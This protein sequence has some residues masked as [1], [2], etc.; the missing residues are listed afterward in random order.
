MLK[1]Q[2]LGVLVYVA[3]MRSLIVLG[4]GLVAPFMLAGCGGASIEDVCQRSCEC[5]DNCDTQQSQCEASGKA[6]EELSD[7]LGCRDSWDAYL[8]CLDENLTCDNGSVDDSACDV[9]FS[10]FQSDCGVDAG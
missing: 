6:F 2:R 5:L 9:E 10:A 4:L 1:S 7:E 3:S 8:S